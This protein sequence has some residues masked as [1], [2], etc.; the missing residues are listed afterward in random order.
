MLRMIDQKVIQEFINNQDIGKIILKN[1]DVK[2]STVVLEKNLETRKIIMSNRFV[3]SQYSSNKL[4]LGQYTDPEQIVHVAKMMGCTHYDP[5]E[6][7]DTIEKAKYNRRLV[8]A[9]LRNQRSAS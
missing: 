8:D 7:E 9:V 3:Y 2:N 6:L 4:S 5:E 1:P